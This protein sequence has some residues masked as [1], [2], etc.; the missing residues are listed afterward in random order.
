MLPGLA[1]P[2]ATRQ[3]PDYLALRKTTTLV[4]AGQPL[5]TPPIAQEYF[6][7]GVNTKLTRRSKPKTNYTLPS[8]MPSFPL[9]FV[10]TNKASGAEKG[11]EPPL[12]VV[13]ESKPADLMDVFARI[14]A[15]EKAVANLPK[16]GVDMGTLL[17]REYEDS[18]RMALLEKRV[19]SLMREGYTENEA[20]SA[21]EAVRMEE[22][23]KKAKEPPKPLPV[24]EAIQEALGVATAA[25]T[26]RRRK[27]R[28]T[29]A[30]LAEETGVPVE[31]LQ[32]GAR[33]ESRGRARAEALAAGI[34]S[35]LAVTY[36]GEGKDQVTK[37]IRSAIMAAR[38]KKK[39]GGE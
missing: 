24:E 37:D 27:G 14:E 30:Q 26:E 28:K 2:S 18:K 29:L 25:V 6:E 16:Y 8:D 10:P 23:V 19:D 13:K 4:V 22:A 17:V 11:E 3:A 1:L 15:E 20:V 36:T 31:E 34:P 21:V 9:G 39:A 35:H 12:I 32:E 33:I 38:Q 7:P 5:S